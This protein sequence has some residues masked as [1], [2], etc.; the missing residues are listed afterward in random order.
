MTTYNRSDRQ[1]L[2]YRLRRWQ[3][4]INYLLAGVAVA[5]LLAPPTPASAAPRCP[6]GGQPDGRGRCIYV[7]RGATCYRVGSV[8][9][10]ITPAQAGEM[11]P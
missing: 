2:R 8:V 6:N 4:A 9:W 5:V 3:R 10:C 7:W 11:Q 1:R